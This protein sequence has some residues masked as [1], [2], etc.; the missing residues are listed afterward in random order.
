MENHNNRHRTLTVMEGRDENAPMV[1]GFKDAAKKKGWSFC[2]LFGINSDKLARFDL[3]DIPLDYVIF[4]EL[5]KN[6]YHEAERIMYWLKKNHKVC[7]NADVAGRRISTSDKHFQQGLF[8][9]DPFLREYALPTFE[10]KNKGN[11]ISYIDGNRIHYPIVLKDRRGTAGKGITLINA[12]P[13]LGQIQDFKN[14]LIEQYI[15]PECDY[16]VFVMGGIA[17]GT[18]R[19]KGNTDNPGDF[20]SWSAGIEKHPEEDPTT[21]A[22][23]TEIATRAAAISKLEYAGIDILRE[24]GTGKLYLL[25]TNIAAGWPNFIPVTHIDIPMLVLDWME[26]IGDNLNLPPS[27]TVPKYIENRLKYLPASIQESYHQILDGTPDVLEQYQAVFDKYPNR[28]LYDAGNIFARLKDAYQTLI[29]SPEKAGDY[30][31]LLTEIES[32]PL[33]WAGNFIGPEVGTLHDGAILSALYL[34][35]LHKIKEI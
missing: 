6:N 3:D 26:E 22:Q 18:M 20:I 12:T 34:F 16:R 31:Q 14:L 30:N 28:Y 29:S 8:M 23:L 21:L 25:E 35:L 4:R 24:E 5:S 17:I 33:S 13:E 11:V 9:M 10:A 19:K 27:T 7:I 15:K 32:M 2:Q 1:D